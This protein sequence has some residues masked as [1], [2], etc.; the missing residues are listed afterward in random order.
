L[1][2]AGDFGAKYWISFGDA[3]EGPRYSFLDRALSSA[4][5]ATISGKIFSMAA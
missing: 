5:P 2:Q 1:D 4:A 3:P